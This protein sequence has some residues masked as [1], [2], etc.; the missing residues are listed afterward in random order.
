MDNPSENGK[1]SPQVLLL[2]APSGRG[3]TTAC[4]R[5][6]ELA[7]SRGLRV[8]GLLSPPVVHDGVKTAITLRDVGTGR[9]RVLARA[10]Q[11]GDGPR[12]GDWTFDPASVT[13]GNQVLASLAP[14]DLLVIDEIGPLE[15][16]LGQGLMNALGV[17]RRGAYRL[18]LVTMRPRLVE[19]ITARLEGL[20]VSVIRLDERNRD[21][22]P[23]TIVALGSKACSACFSAGL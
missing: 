17:L 8:G 19:T 2:M 11:A 6:V 3:K 21:Q 23:Q 16:E 5:A 18:A 9:E 20:E 7:R 22:L 15:L 12:V 13:W 10:H 14:C 1:R 4:Q